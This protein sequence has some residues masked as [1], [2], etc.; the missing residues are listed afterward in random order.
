MGSAEC[1]CASHD[2]ACDGRRS[3]PSGSSPNG[4]G[5]DRRRGGSRDRRGIG[6]RKRWLA[7]DRST[8]GPTGL[9]ETGPIK[10]ASAIAVILSIHPVILVDLTT[11]QPMRAA[12]FAQLALLVCGGLVFAAR[13]R[14]AA[15]RTQMNQLFRSR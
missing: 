15:E 10:Q 14:P 1:Y 8:K 3:Q 4:S 7:L 6:G 11:S 12:I 5:E 13:M 9:Q 2:E